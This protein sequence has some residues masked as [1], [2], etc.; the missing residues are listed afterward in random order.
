MDEAT[1][2]NK[3]AELMDE[4]STLPKA[5]RDKLTTL[6][7]ETKQRHHK[8]RKTVTDLQESLDYLR[9]AI[10]YLVFDIEATRR[11]NRYLREMLEQQRSGEDEAGGD[12]TKGF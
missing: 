8:L 7:A 11:E 3:L 9:V 12:G 5:E 6:A 4:I 2:Q 1:F 10:K